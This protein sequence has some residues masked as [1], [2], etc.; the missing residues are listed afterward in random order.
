MSQVGRE[1]V[2]EGEL[3]GQYVRGAMF[4]TPVGR[5]CGWQATG[6]N[7]PSLVSPGQAPWYFELLG[8][9]AKKKQIDAGLVLWD[10][11]NGLLAKNECANIIK[12]TFTN[13]PTSLLS[14]LCCL[15]VNKRINFKILTLA[16]HMQPLAF[17]QPTY[18]F[19]INTSSASAQLT[20]ICYL[21]HAATAVLDKEIFLL[22]P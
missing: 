3:S 1:I 13:L 6:C 9:A 17:G 5:L 16:Y 18:L 4:Y 15:P 8:P 10:L 2:R 14:E 19:G 22:R 11:F 12:P 20:R 21:C 7:R